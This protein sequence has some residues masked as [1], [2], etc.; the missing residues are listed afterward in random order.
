VSKKSAL[1]LLL[2]AVFLGSPVRA[3]EQTRQVQEELR[4][5]HL[6]FRDIDG[7]TTPDYSIA[8]RRY[9]ERQGFPATG[10][11]DEITLY[12]LGIG[13]PLPPAEGVAELPDVAVLKSDAALRELKPRPP[14]PI[15]AANTAVA[16]SKTE[17][18]NFIRRY[19]DA[20]QS[21]N[22]Q[23]EL[24]FYADRVD[25]FDHGVVDK[26]YIQNELAVYDQRWPS[27]KYSIG[28]SLRV[29]KNG[30]NTLAKLRVGFDVANSA[31][32]RKARGKTDNTFGLIKSGDSLKIASIKEARVRRPSRHRRRPPSFPAAVGRTVHKVFRSIFH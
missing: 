22:P 32:D 1:L 18:R 5:R 26:T 7:R 13:E 23:D 17:I 4:K 9:Q 27:R 6:F 16:A 21:S 30:N 15:K 14:E 11:A 19:L 2:L 29:V 12:S 25:Y 24:P 3:D 10:I 31:H 8:L 20:S 28:D